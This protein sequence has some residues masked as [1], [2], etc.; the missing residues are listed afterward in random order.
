MKKKIKLTRPQLAIM[1]SIHT[2][3]DTSAHGLSPLGFGA[4]FHALCRKGLVD[5]GKLTPLGQAA[6]T[7]PA[8]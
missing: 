2:H 3:G 8:K 7:K 5:G 1:K 6:F 4:A